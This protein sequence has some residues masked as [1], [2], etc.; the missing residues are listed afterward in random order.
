[1]AKRSVVVASCISGDGNLSKTFW[2]WLSK[3][4]FDI[5]I[6]LWSVLSTSSSR[7]S[8][9]VIFDLDVHG[10]VTEGKE[11]MPWA[12]PRK[13][14]CFTSFEPTIE[15]FHGTIKTV[16]DLCQKLAVDLG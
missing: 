12:Y 3:L 15:R 10:W 13:S 11:A 8:Q 9:H 16:V 14:R 1:M 2:C 7:Q 5:W 4:G 6:D